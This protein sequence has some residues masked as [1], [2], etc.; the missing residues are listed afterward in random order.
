MTETMTSEPTTQP[1]GPE[2]SVPVKGIYVTRDERVIAVHELKIG[3]LYKIIGALKKADLRSAPP[4]LS[5]IQMA[6]LAAKDEDIITNWWET[7]NNTIIAW[8]GSAP[9]LL[10]AVIQS[11][12]EI[13]DEEINDLGLADLIGILNMGIE[14]SDPA[15]LVEVSRGFFQHIGGLFPEDKPEGTTDIGDVLA[16]AVTAPAGDTKTG[17]NG[18]S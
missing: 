17:V 8:L 1:I 2:S 6:R 11:F 7:W 16:A 9:D 18:S 13:S 3:G 15:G 5:A 10:N 14:Q 4:V 12:A